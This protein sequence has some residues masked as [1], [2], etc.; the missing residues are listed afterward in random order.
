[1]QVTAKLSWLFSLWTHSCFPFFFQLHLLDCSVTC[2]LLMTDSD[3][4]C[5]LAAEALV[6]K[7]KLK[8]ETYSYSHTTHRLYAAYKKYTAAYCCW[9]INHHL[10]WQYS[11]NQNATYQEAAQ[12]DALTFWCRPQ[13]FLCSKLK[14]INECTSCLNMHCR[15]A[16]KLC[17]VPHNYKW[18]NYIMAICVIITQLPK[19]TQ[20]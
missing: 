13:G 15:L 4:T 2:S 11:C 6:S 18:K 12:S 8:F 16:W 14:N 17:S 10:A 1:M 19:R 9:C 20:A 7:H 3:W 5:W